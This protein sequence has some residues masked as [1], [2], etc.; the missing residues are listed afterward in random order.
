MAKRCTFRISFPVV[1]GATP[2]QMND[3][4][5]EIVR[6]G[7]N[8]HGKD[9]T[10]FRIDNVTIGHRALKRAAEIKERNAQLRDIP[11]DR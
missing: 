3:A 4:M 6:T 10:L 2:K 11:D 1:D 9:Y 5:R 8:A 7:C